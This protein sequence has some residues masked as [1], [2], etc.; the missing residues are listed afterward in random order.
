MGAGSIDFH[1][2][3]FVGTITLTPDTGPQPIT[4]EMLTILDEIRDRISWGS[5]LRFI[6]ITGSSAFAFESFSPGESDSYHIRNSFA[7]PSI[8]S[9]IEQ[10][11]QPVMAVI[12]GDAVGHGLELALTCDI[13]IASESA[14]FGFPNVKKGIMPFDGGTQRL[15]RIVGRA[16]AMEILLTGETFS[17][18]E[19]KRIGLVSS[20]ADSRNLP[21]IVETISSG[22]VSNAP[23]A[24]A[25]TKEA[26][27]K[28]M[29]MTLSQG[30]SL[31]ADLY[32]LIHTTEDRR[33]GIQAFR[34]KTTA[35]F[36]GE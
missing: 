34:D 6:I 1:R 24:V 36:T 8:C 14:R 12:E 28:G 11:K 18:A 32:F 3:N 22:I 30:L 23:I 9:I 17:A 4:P 16:K 13:R 29:D 26:I 27:K 7:H 25:Y 2:E 21:D 5:D 33:R 31:E 15:P 19:A 20:I 35:A 10:I